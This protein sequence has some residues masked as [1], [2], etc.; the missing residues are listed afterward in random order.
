MA[1]GRV[2]PV[3]KLYYG[4]PMMLTEN[5]SVSSGQ[6]NGSFLTLKSVKV[7]LGERPMEI[8]LL[9]GTKVRA[10][11][12][13]QIASNTVRHEVQ[14]IKPQEFELV[15]KK[16]TFTATV[17]IEYKRSVMQMKGIQ[18]P[19]ISNGVTTGHTLQGC[20]LD[21]LTVFELFYGQN[22]IYVILSCVRTMARLFFRNLFQMTSQSTLCLLQ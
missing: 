5:K 4:C 9:C 1:S 3:L 14:D 13:S 12:A 11:F 17:T 2:D 16:L 15:S 19:M 10:Y 6:A 22:W 8:Q 7:K 21:W 20:S 18:F